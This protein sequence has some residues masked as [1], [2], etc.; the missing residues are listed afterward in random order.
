M[1]EAPPTDAYIAGDLIG[2]GLKQVANG[3]YERNMTGKPR[4]LMTPRRWAE[5]ERVLEVGRLVP[6]AAFVMLW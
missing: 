4:E 6:L 1:H 5:S 2:F 3:E